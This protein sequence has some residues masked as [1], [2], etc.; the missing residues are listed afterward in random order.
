MKKT[1]LKPSRKPKRSLSV[2]ER[3]KASYLAAKAALPPLEDVAAK[4]LKR[5]ETYTSVTSNLL[6]G[7]LS[8]EIA[9]EPGREFNPV[10]DAVRELLEREGFT[11]YADRDN[12]R[13]LR[14]FWDA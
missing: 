14:V 1:H 11:V 7:H 12:H 13:H 4:Y 8:L 10:K 3:I 5:I 9:P 6:Q 2:A